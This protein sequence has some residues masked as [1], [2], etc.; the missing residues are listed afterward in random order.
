MPGVSIVPYP[1]FPS[2]LTPEHW[3]GWHGAPLLVIG[4]YSKFL[5]TVTR[6]LW[7]PFSRR[8]RSPERQQGWVFNTRGIRPTT[9]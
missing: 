1:V 6:P 3:S 5:A 4:E 2:Q 8:G 9:G 7:N